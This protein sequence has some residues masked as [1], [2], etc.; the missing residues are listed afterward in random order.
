ME[1]KTPKKSSN[2]KFINPPLWMDGK[3]KVA[4]LKKRRA[5]KKYSYA[6]YGIGQVINKSNE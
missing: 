5:W 6:R 4:I 1:K 3:T 2:N